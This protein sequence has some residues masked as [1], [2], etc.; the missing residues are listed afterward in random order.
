MLSINRTENYIHF[1]IGV[2]PTC[3]LSDL[4]REIKK[5]STAFI[6]ERQSSKFKFQ[7]QEGFGAF[8]YSQSQLDD[9]IGYIKN[10][11]QHHRHKSF[12]EEYL[13]F[14]KVFKIELKPNICF[15]GWM[16]VKNDSRIKCL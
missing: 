6:K 12:K 11:K 3:C 4:V 16:N 9:I 15:D 1:L 14:L 5:A 10:Q 13:S 2:K 8:S 7:W